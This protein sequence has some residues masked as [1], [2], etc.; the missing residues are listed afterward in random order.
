[1]LAGVGLRSPPRTRTFSHPAPRSRS[2]KSH[3]SSRGRKVTG[4]KP[5]PTRHHRSNIISTSGWNWDTSLRRS[6]WID[7]TLL[8][9]VNANLSFL[10]SLSRDITRVPAPKDIR[11]LVRWR[12]NLYR[13][14]NC[15]IYLRHRCRVRAHVSCCILIERLAIQRIP[16]FLSFW[17]VAQYMMLRSSFPNPR[18]QDRPEGGIKAVCFSPERSIL[19]TG[20]ENGAIRVTRR[21]DLG[22]DGLTNA[23]TFSFGI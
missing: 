21:H 7:C 17:D 9:P 6:R 23:P 15:Y 22:L 13:R 1:M 18:R 4:C 8:H 10:L 2:M 12:T 3:G 19:A 11:C 16:L 5:S 20:H 14:S